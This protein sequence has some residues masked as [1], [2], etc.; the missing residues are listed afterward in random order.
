MSEWLLEFPFLVLYL[1]CLCYAIL[2]DIRA[3]KIPNWISITLVVGFVLYAILSWGKLDLL[4]R[5]LVT[6]VI[7]CVSFVFFYRNWLGGGDVK[8]LAAVSLWVGPAH[9]LAF[10]IIMGLL[11]VLLAI[12]MMWLRPRLDAD[13]TLSRLKAPQPV[14]RW[15]RE[16]VCP[17]GLAIGL[18]GLAMVPRVFS[19]MVPRVFS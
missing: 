2:S 12:T 18:A 9:I 3:L 14:A 1:Y 16:G 15:I 17:Y 13:A 11:G 6:A 10:V 4:M 19:W 7:F 5:L 8:L